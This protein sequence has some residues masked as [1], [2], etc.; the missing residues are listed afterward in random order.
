MIRALEEYLRSEVSLKRYLHSLR[1]ANTV[2]LLCERFDLPAGEGWTAGMAHDIAREWDP[3]Q[4][5]EYARR[6]GYG[7]SPEESRVPLLLHGRAAAAELQSRYG[8]RRETVLQ[9][10]RWHTTGHPDMGSLG[11]AL[12]C[13][14]Y[15]EPGRPHIDRH[16]Y[17]R[18]MRS[19][20]MEE[21]TLTILNTEIERMHDLARPVIDH[22]Y[23]LRSMLVQRIKRGAAVPG[24]AGMES[25]L[26]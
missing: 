26:K 14:D 4:L 9:A 18:L 1:V 19:A 24:K 3:Q 11:M 2:V 20:S 23:A 5:M 6:D 7:I 8:E 15:I 10:V 21:M 25:E 13:A 16:E 12:Y 17:E 22:T